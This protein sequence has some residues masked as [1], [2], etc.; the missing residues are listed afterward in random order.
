MSSH[1]IEGNHTK[2]CM[3]TYQVKSPLLFWGG[4]RHQRVTRWDVT[5]FAP[6]NV[7]NLRRYC[8]AR[9][10]DTHP[11]FPRENTEWSTWN[12]WTFMA[13]GSDI[14]VGCHRLQMELAYQRELLSATTRSRSKQKEGRLWMRKRD[15]GRGREYRVEKRFLWDHD[16]WERDINSCLPTEIPFPKLLWVGPPKMVLAGRLTRMIPT[17]RQHPRWQQFSSLLELSPRSPQLIWDTTIA[18]ADE[19]EQ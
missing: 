5:L 12:W 1:W 3:E 14:T 9:M 7:F 11:Q 6:I 13:T 2:S 10:W 17:C 18:R 4:G 19:R 8:S 16:V 15:E